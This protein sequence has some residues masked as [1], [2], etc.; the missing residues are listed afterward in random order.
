VL[1]RHGSPEAISTNGLRSCKA[2]S[3]PTVL[4]SA[5]TFAAIVIF[6]ALISVLTLR[7]IVKQWVWYVNP[8]PCLYYRFR[9][10]TFVQTLK[11]C[12]LD[13]VWQLCLSS[14]NESRF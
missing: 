4:L 3:Y 11:N 8:S 12:R 14:H 1:K 5:V 7:Q 2:A 13:L 10:K 9:S 6:P